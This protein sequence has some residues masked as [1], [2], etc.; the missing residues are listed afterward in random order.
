[1]PMVC[2]LLTFAGMGSL[3]I[4]APKSANGASNGKGGGALEEASAQSPTMTGGIAHG[5]P[6]SS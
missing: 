1:M 6:W 3:E 2:S 5:S 4:N